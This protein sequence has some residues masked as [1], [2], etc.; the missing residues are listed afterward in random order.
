MIE[1]LKPAF[2][3]RL[4]SMYAGESQQ[5]SAGWVEI[6]DTTRIDES[7]GMWLHNLCLSIKPQRTLEVGMAYGFSTLYILAAMER[8]GAGHHTA[9]D[10]GQQEYFHDVGAMNVMAVGMNGRFS[11]LREKSSS[12]L[13]RFGAEGQKFDLLFIDGSHL[14]DDV[15]MDFTLSAAVCPIG[16]SIVFDD[17]WLPA[18]RT[19][20]SW[21]RS[22]RR[23]FKELDS[24]ECFAHF[25]RASEDKREWNHF[26]DFTQRTSIQHRIAR[27]VKRAI[28]SVRSA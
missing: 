3:D 4:A 9:I 25:R 10:P 11:L 2:R 14:F 17:A 27:R 13:A 12:V 8:L 21:V 16:G 24:N 20:I 28:A 26:V 22:N 23:D 6:D 15:L 7:S 1:T 19:V 5:G 18:V